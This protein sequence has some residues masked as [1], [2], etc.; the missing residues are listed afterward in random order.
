MQTLQVK[1]LRPN[2]V[3]PKRATDGSAGYD[4]FA[5]IDEPVVI[6]PGEWR[7]IPTG[8]ALGME[9]S[10]VAAFIFARSGLAVKHGL[11]LVNSVAVIDSDYRG[12]LM[13]SIINNGGEPYTVAPG[14]RFAQLVLM[15]VLT[16]ELVEVEEL[17]DTARG[18]GGFGSTGR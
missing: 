12:E 6:P 5:C 13:T 2:A 4:L 10:G 18:T 1:K 7:A 11:T 3:I 17:S 9:D 15:P 16:P 14:D 8:V